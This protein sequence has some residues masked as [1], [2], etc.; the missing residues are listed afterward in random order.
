[1]R[2]IQRTNTWS[3]K[4]LI[5]RGCIRLLKNSSS[6]ARYVN[7]TRVSEHMLP[8]GLLQPLPIPEGVWSDISMD[9]IE[10]LTKSKGKSVVPV[11]VDRFSKYAHF[12]A[13]QHPFNAVKMAKVFFDNVFKLHGLPRTIVSDRDQIFLGEFWQELFRWQGASFNLSSYHHHIDG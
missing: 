7:R 4:C 9:F 12:L 1:M 2:A 8:A 3:N 10:G 13:L 11:V 5:G 6:N